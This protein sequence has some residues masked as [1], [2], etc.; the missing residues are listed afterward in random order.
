MNRVNKLLIALS[1]AMLLIV[2]VPEAL[3]YFST[4][5]YTKGGR[6]LSFANDSKIEEKMSG[7]TK[8]IKVTA[9]PNSGDIYVRVR[10]YAPDLPYL[11][12]G[13]I[14]GADWSSSGDYW[15]YGKVLKAG[16]STSVLDVPIVVD[17]DK[18]KDTK[19]GDQ[20][21]V[22]VIYE[23]VPVTYDAKGNAQNP[24]W[25][26]S[27]VTVTTETE[28]GSTETGEGGVTNEG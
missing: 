6:K 5:T 11:S 4:Y 18:A 2:S 15:V 21:H 23:S 1:V 27:E 8:K 3:S 22:I 7:N 12:I 14:A 13:T 16:D 20:F 25:T 28:T 19:E 26:S 17:P 10:I 9:N 24:D